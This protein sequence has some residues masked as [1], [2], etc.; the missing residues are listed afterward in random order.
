MLGSATGVGSGIAI[1]EVLKTHFQQFGSLYE[2]LFDNSM[3]TGQS[4]PKK[5]VTL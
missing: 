3:G 5:S 1:P 4:G 2:D